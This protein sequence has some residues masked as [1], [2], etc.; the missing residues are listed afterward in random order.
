MKNLSIAFFLV[1]SIDQLQAQSVFSRTYGA[2]QQQKRLMEAT[3]SQ[4]QP[5]DGAV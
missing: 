1:L 3:C 2:L 4:D 5:V